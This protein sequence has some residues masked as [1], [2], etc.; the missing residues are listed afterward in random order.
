MLSVNNI[1]RGVHDIIADLLL[2][3]PGTF[4]AALVIDCVIIVQNRKHTS[5]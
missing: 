4:F 5:L 3:L 1:L 2:D